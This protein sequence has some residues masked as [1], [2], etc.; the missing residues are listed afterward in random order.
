MEGSY[1]VVFVTWERLGMGLRRAAWI[2]TEDDA[3]IPH[4][5]GSEGGNEGHVGH[6]SWQHGS[7]VDK[8]AYCDGASALN[9]IWRH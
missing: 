9:I 8:C 3:A 6:Q 5:E 1:V 2:L 4:E 7:E